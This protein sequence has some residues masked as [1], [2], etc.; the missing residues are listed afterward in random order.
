MQQNILSKMDFKA[1]K[2]VLKVDFNQEVQ[3]RI[4]LNDSVLNVIFRTYEK[5]NAKCSCEQFSF[6]SYYNARI[7]RPLFM[8]RTVFTI[9]AGKEMK[10]K[11]MNRRTWIIKVIL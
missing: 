5:G 4:S 11:S 3:L 7:L 10:E 1:E 2:S 9:S 6:S 8:W